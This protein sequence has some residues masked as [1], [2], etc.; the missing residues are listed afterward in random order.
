MLSRFE[1]IPSCWGQTIY[2]QHPKTELSG[3]VEFNTGQDFEWQKQ[4]GG[5]AFEIRTIRFSDV[6]CNCF[7]FRVLA[8]GLKDFVAHGISQKTQIAKEGS[9]NLAR[10]PKINSVVGILGH[11]G[12]TH[13]REVCSSIRSMAKESL[14]DEDEVKTRP[15]WTGFKIAVRHKLLTHYKKAKVL[16]D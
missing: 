8:V 11:L 3:L 16:Y 10:I 13:E 1:R 6:H 9:I 5:Q 7:D 2:S 4:N 14:S 15:V 12:G